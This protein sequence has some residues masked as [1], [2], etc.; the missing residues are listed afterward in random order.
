MQQRKIFFNCIAELQKTKMSITFLLAIALIA[1]VLLIVGFFHA[2]TQAMK[3]LQYSAPFP[4]INPFDSNLFHAYNQSI[5]VFRGDYLL[6]TRHDNRTHMNSSG[7]IYLEHKTHVFGNKYIADRTHNYISVHYK[8][9]R[10]ILHLPELKGMHSKILWHQ[11]YEDPRAFVFADRL[12][13]TAAVYTSKT[14]RVAL[15]E[16]EM[17]NEPEH[18]FQFK[19][20]VIL[21]DRAVAVDASLPQKNWCLFGEEK[22]RIVTD[23]F[24]EMKIYDICLE[25]GADFGKMSQPVRSSTERLFS[26]VSADNRIRCST[27][28]VP[29]RDTDAAGKTLVCAVHTRSKTRFSTA[30]FRTM[31][32]EVDASTFLP[33]RHS[34]MRRYSEKESTRIEFAAGLCWDKQHKKLKLSLGIEDMRNKVVD[35]MPENLF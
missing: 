29:F 27:S 1:A 20:G 4:K 24:P 17:L 6:M 34:P 12:F 22:S 18:P 35:L 8:G 5:T 15:V 33:L 13:F 23:V 28:F 16:L 32:L 31:F 11:Q 19:Q 7:L 26:D 9:K 21:D 14:V 2:Q 30:R 3:V 25:S 10:Q